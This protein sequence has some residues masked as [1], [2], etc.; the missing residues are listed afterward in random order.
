MKVYHVMGGVATR[1]GEKED[2]KLAVIKRLML[3]GDGRT[4]LIAGVAQRSAGG[5]SPMV[6]VDLS[7]MDWTPIAL[8]GD[9]AP[10][11]T[12]PRKLPG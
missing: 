9:E 5:A 6:R 12:E 7:T 8:P 10:D 3:S 2:W 4:L 11:D 1:I